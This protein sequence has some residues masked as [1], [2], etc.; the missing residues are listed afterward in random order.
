MGKGCGGAG[1]RHVGSVGQICASTRTLQRSRT[2]RS[3]TRTLRPRIW[4]CRTL[5]CNGDGFQP[6]RDTCRSEGWCFTLVLQRL[7]VAQFFGAR[8]K[9]FQVGVHQRKGRRRF[10]GTRFTLSS[11]KRRI[12]NSRRGGTFPR[13]IRVVLRGRRAWPGL[14]N[15]HRGCLT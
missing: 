2:W 3:R 4:R 10:R 7:S 9:A 14:N 6:I 13:H 11:N 12:A 5:R 1:Q 15:T 8:G